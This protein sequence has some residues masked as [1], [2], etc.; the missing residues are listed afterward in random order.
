MSNNNLVSDDMVGAALRYLSENTAASA[1]AK[2]DR[3]MAEHLRKR[4]RAQVIMSSTQTTAGMREAEAEAS[5]AYLAACEDE[6]NAIEAD[7]YHRAA[8]AKAE[9]II[10][11]W[12]TENANIR[13]AERVR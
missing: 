7:E 10:S 3:V 2:A 6:R 8:R 4:T 13:A 5:N 9:A 12:Q 11:A 1:K